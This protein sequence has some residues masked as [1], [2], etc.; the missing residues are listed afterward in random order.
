M[1]E[2]QVTLHFRAT[3]TEFPVTRGLTMTT[4]F[5]PDR[6]YLPLWEVAAIRGAA[7]AAAGYLFTDYA[8]WPAPEEGPSVPTGPPFRVTVEEIG[9]P[10]RT[11]TLDLGATPEQQR[12]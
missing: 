4:S 2:F 9:A 3:G 10:A 8:D 7:E 6:G 1:T 11:M 12:A 5:G